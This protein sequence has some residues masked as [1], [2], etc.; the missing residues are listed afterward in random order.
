MVSLIIPD[1]W[2]Q[3]AVSF[4]RDGRDLVV[5]APTGSGKTY[6]FELLYDTLRGQAVYT[7]PTRALANDKLAEWR[8]RGWDVGIS[9]GDVAENLEAKVVVATLETQKG[10]FLQRSGPRLLVVDEYQL[11][12]D[13]IRGTNYELILS[14]APPET[15]LLLLSG[16]VA[17][18]ADVVAWLRRIGR[19]AELVEHKERPVRL[20]E[21]MLTDLPIGAPASVRGYWPKLIA[22]ALLSDLG[23][24]LIF[25]PRRQAAEDLAAALS[26]ALPAEDPLALSQEQALA[27]GESMAKLLRNRIAYHHSGL[28]YVVRAG[29][30]EPLAKKGHLRVV[31]AT[32]GLAAGINFSMRSVLITGTQ[33]QAG[34]FQRQVRPD[35][36]LQMFGR[37]GRRGLDEMG[38]ALITPELPRLH[39]AYPLKLRRPDPI[40]WPS[41]LA[42]MQQASIRQED[43]FVAALR[44]SQRLFTARPL[45]LGI[46]RY[47]QES[48]L[49]RSDIETG[50]VHRC[51]LPV[52]AERGRLVRRHD[53]EMLTPSGDWE[54]MLSPALTTLGQIWVDRHGWRPLLSVPSEATSLGYGNLCKIF[55]GGRSFEYGRE[56]AIASL[57]D[58]GWLLAKGVRRLIREQRPLLDLRKPISAEQIREQ[59]VPV[60]ESTQNAQCVLLESRNRTLFCRFSFSA[61]PATGYPDSQGRFL[62]DPP[63]RRTYPEV[64]TSCAYKS[65]CEAIE[66]LTSPAFAWRDLELVQ[67]D[68]RP[69]RRGIVFSF[70]NQGEGLAVAAGLEQSDYSIEDLVFDLANLRA[71]HRFSLDETRAGDRL[72]AICQ[73]T[74]RRSEYEG[75]LT[76][77]LPTAYGQGAAELV[78]ELV[79]H[80]VSRHKLLSESVR[81]GDIERA[82]TEWRSL[83]RQITQAPDLDWDR[84]RALKEAAEKY[85]NR[86]Q[87]PARQPHP[88]LLPAQ[89]RRYLGRMMGRP[90]ATPSAS[91]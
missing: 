87:S 88:E 78:R 15:Q 54:R 30:V 82:V 74:Y 72:G 40:D 5:H 50:P 51:G 38:Y 58:E 91:P 28:G 22:R 55:Q 79:E 48:A 25:C 34:N 8:A 52:D 81:H 36:L 68:G 86:T 84:W 7:V 89:M 16:S 80:Q 11:M 45:A 14:L 23:P 35:E 69:T 9:T 49:D 17:N 56:L 33:Y 2:Q 24:I 19:T 75:Y 63:T 61:R 70:F 77:G 60:L 85:V 13:P 90:R 64:C 42:V 37:A 83:L 67:P 43:P 76:M 41:L 71:G 1:K 44:V 29:I 21:V 4:L 66:L 39:E 46:E 65:S 73:E 62:Q 57:T 10:R 18:P 3:D 26:G 12:A 20:D 59:V 47:Y 31:V 32:M 27:C 6:I 53:L